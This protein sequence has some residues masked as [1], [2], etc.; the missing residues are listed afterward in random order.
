MTVEG[1]RA[2]RP[3]ER[4]SL[5]AMLNSVFRPGRRGDMFGEYMLLFREGNLAHLTVMLEQGEVVS[6]VGMAVRWLSFEGVALKVSSGRTRGRSTPR[7]CTVRVC[8]S[9]IGSTKMKSPRSPER[10]VSSSRSP[11]APRAASNSIW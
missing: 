1:P 8:T 10:G 9:L 5:R 11:F 3:E 2:I 4:A 7:N 6:H